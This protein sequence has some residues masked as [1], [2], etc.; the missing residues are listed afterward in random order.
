MRE[1]LP[2]TH[3]RIHDDAEANKNFDYKKK[4][5][6]KFSFDDPTKDSAHST[7]KRAIREVADHR[8]REK[9]WLQQ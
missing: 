4:G 6:R 2:Q 1:P 3:P 5:K 7:L 8:F 9:E